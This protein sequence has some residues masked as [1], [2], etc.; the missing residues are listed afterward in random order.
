LRN[1]AD[2]RGYIIV[3]AGRRARIGEAKVRADRAKRYLIEAQGVKAERIIT[4]DGGYRERPTVDLYLVPRNARTVPIPT[5]TVDS[6]EV[7]TIKGSSIRNTK[8]RASR[9]Q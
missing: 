7:E 3:Y 5:P 9:P 6:N 2:A 8:R 4:V 1:D